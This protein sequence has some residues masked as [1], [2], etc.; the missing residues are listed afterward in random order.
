MEQMTNEFNELH[1]ENE[2]EEFNH[3]YK[4]AHYSKIPM[5]LRTLENLKVFD[6]EIQKKV[7]TSSL[8]KVLE[9]G[10]KYC[11]Q[12][13]DDEDCINS[14]ITLNDEKFVKHQKTYNFLI[15]RNSE[16]NS[17]D[18]ITKQFKTLNFQD[19]YKVS[20]EHTE[21]YI[22]MYELLE[23]CSQYHN[24]KKIITLDHQQYI[25]TI[26]NSDI[27]ERVEFIILL[28]ESDVNINPLHII[29]DEMPDIHIEMLILINLISKQIK[30]YHYWCKFHNVKW[31]LLNLQN[32]IKY[33]KLVNNY[34]SLVFELAFNY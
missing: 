1:I 2:N 23:Q 26:I 6:K 3:Y 22:K 18:Q 17:E 29:Y 4:N 13:F 20:D 28:F 11:Y 19:I 10:N 12:H 27:F 8:E 21:L 5:L 25:A 15:T 9:I 32:K 33:M 34:I 16:L 7:S 30:L 31:D 24:S 14:W